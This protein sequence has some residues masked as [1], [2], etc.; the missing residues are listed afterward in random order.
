MIGEVR[1]DHVPVRRILSTLQLT[2]ARRRRKLRRGSPVPIAAL[3]LG[4]SH[5]VRG[6]CE[7]AA[8]TLRAPGTGTSCLCYWI[9]VEHAE[10][11]PDMS[12]AW[13]PRAT[14]QAGTT[15]R[16]DDRTGQVLVDA[17]SPGGVADVVWGYTARCESSTLQRVIPLGPAWSPCATLASGY[18]VG[19][20]WC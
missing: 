6:R 4:S 3:A 11:G 17:A 18:F 5:L 14:A 1:R 15:F 9:S 7:A 19:A 8:P 13:I 2:G 12:P 20:A 10:E 16:L